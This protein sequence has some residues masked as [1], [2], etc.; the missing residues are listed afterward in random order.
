MRTAVLLL[1]WHAAA[2]ASPSTSDGDE[3]AYEAR[4]ASKLGDFGTANASS[5]M[6]NYIRRFDAQNGRELLHYLHS[7]PPHYV[8]SPV[9]C[10]GARLGG[11]VAAFQ[12]LHHVRLALGVDLNPGP[13]NTH[14]LYGNARTQA[15]S[16]TQYLGMRS[17]AIRAA[18]WTDRLGAF[19]NGSFGSVFSNVLDHVLHIDRFAAEAHRVLV[20]NGTLLVHRTYYRGRDPQPIATMRRASSA[21]VSAAAVHL[22]S[23]AMDH[24]AVHDNAKEHA[25]MLG[26]IEGTFTRSRTLVVR[27][28]P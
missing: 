19:K 9:L 8:G 3:A 20:P 23:M 12:E 21:F 13:R 7:L 17:S 6:D 5:K 4:Q 15:A 25:A 14:V 1:L 2:C 26:T 10:V 18:S 24:W 28:S 27:C 16:R 11:E 22:N